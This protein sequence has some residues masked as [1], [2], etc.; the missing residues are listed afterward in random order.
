MRQDLGQ[1][2][3]NMYVLHADWGVIKN[4]LTRGRG[5]SQPLKHTAFHRVE[6]NTLHD[7]SALIRGDSHDNQFIGNDFISAGVRFD[8][9]QEG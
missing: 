6:N 3:Q 9:L 2:S 7:R 8:A 5:N 1:P 4:S